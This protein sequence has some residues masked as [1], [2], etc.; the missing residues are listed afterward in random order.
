MIDL[1]E[2]SEGEFLLFVTRK[3]I[4]KKTEL[5]AFSNPRPSGIIALG[6][7]DDDVVR[8]HGVQIRDHLAQARDL[9][10]E[11]AVE[12][13][14]LATARQ[15]RELVARERLARERGLFCR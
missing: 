11:A 13:L 15:L 3:G 5:S 1:K 2:Y 6:V 10:V 9:H 12:R 4:V 14:E 7:E 8:A